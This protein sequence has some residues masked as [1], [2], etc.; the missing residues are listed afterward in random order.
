[1][2][3]SFCQKYLFLVSFLELLSH[4]MINLEQTKEESQ[5]EAKLLK[6]APKRYETEQK[7]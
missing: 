7:F 1:M 6:L 5:K 3:W 2:G 4:P